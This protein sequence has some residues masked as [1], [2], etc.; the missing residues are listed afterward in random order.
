M[1]DEFVADM[2]TLLPATVNRLS[3]REAWKE[4][5]PPG[6]SDDLD[7]YLV[8]TVAQMYHYTYY[9]AFD[10][11]REGYAIKHDGKP[12][13]VLPFVEQRWEKG[14]AISK[15][16]HEDG[17][18]KMEIY[19]D[20]LLETMLI[21]QADGIE[22]LVVLPVANAAPNY[23][24]EHTE[25]PLW[26]SA[27]DQIF[28]PPILQNVGAPDIMIPI[29]DVLVPYIS[30]VTKR[31]EYLPV[32]IDIMGTPKRDLQLLQAVEKVLDSSG[33]R[34]TAAVS[35]RDQEFFHSAEVVRSEV[36]TAIGKSE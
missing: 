6:T 33:R 21:G 5:H 10:G 2:V 23:R 1:I 29:G 36:S 12:L 19:R 20:W 7:E 27:L 13:Y 30:K 3:I 8:D 26:K 35:Q 32:V 31:T 16:E 28:L 9:H 22:P 11:F 34:S 25:S 18:K 4:S 15:A 14:A 17:T 24:D